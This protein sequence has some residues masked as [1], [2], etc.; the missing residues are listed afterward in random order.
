MSKYN[1]NYIHRPGWN[2]YVRSHYIASS[3]AFLLWNESGRPRHGPIFEIKK[4]AQARFKY[5]L[6]FIK[7]NEDSLRDDALAEKLLEGND[8][9]FWKGVKKINK[10]LQSQATQI[11]GVVGAVNIAELWKKHYEELFN[12]IKSKVP[13]NIKIEN[14]DGISVSEEE[15]LFEIR[16]LKKNKAQGND[17]LSAEH[18]KFADIS[19]VSILSKCF[20][21]FLTHGFLPESMLSVAITPVVKDAKSSISCKNNYRPIAIASVISKLFERI[22]LHRMTEYLETCPNQFGY[23]QKLGT[24]SCIFTLKELLNKYNS[25]N[26]TIFLCFLDASKAFDCVNHSKLFKTLVDI[27]V[28]GYIVRILK[29]WYEHQSMFVKWGEGQS[30]SFKVGNGVRQGGI[31]SPYLFNIYVN[32]LSKDLNSLDIGCTIGST[33]INHLMYADD[34]VLVS[35]SSKGLQSLLN[36][37]EEFS[38]NFDVKFN[39]S[40][41]HYMIVRAKSH[42]HNSYPDMIFCNQTLKEVTQVKYLGHIVS[43]DLSDNLDMMRHCRFLYA[44]GNN[45]NR[46]FSKCTFSVK[47]KLFN[48]YCTSM[49]TSQL[50]SK[51]KNSSLNKVKVAYNNI[52]RLFFNM[53]RFEDGRIFSVSN[54]SVCN[55]IPTFDALLRKNCFSFISRILCS[56]NKLITSCVSID[57]E[58]HSIRSSLWRHWREL[59]YVVG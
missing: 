56:Y 53:S 5:A 39:S 42:M 54:F 27:Q 31:L 13:Y 36:T 23:K 7:N 25:Y 19:I 18:L 9:D 41:S 24:D 58:S 16:N 45:I 6:R 8:K 40:K 12:R 10:P 38:S 33:K 1:S 3:E 14:N 21:C 35:A 37:C 34:I 50:W 52:I 32:N 51:F 11:D 46:K 47:V 44:Q 26:S 55:N 43:S 17:Q 28:P 48:A 49:Y 20:T 30:T 57:L 22:L 2:D 29:Y 15:V 59:L 4:R